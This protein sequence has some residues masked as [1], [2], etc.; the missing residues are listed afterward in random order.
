[1]EQEEVLKIKEYVEIQRKDCRKLNEWLNSVFEPNVKSIV[2]WINAFR[3]DFRDC[4][5]EMADLIL[6]LKSLN[7]FYEKIESIDSQ[8]GAQCDWSKNYLNLLH[9][10][11]TRYSFAFLA[12][13][14]CNEKSISTAMNNDGWRRDVVNIILQLRDRS[15]EINIR[16][17][18]NAFAHLENFTLFK[19]LN[20]NF[21]I[22]GA[23]GSGKSSF[24]RRTR[25]ILG[26]NVV[27]IASQKFFEFRPVNSWSIGNNCRQNLWKY[28]GQDKLYKGEH[29]DSSMGEDLTTVVSALFEEK[30][31]LATDYF[32]RKTTVRKDSTLEKVIDL[33]EKILV[34]RKL[35]VDKGNI[36]VLTSKGSK[37][38]FM[39][40]SDGEKVVFYYV[41]HILL[42]KENSYIIVDEPENHLH[43]ALI[44][45]LWD[46]LEQARPDCQ[47]IYLTHNLEF[48]ASRNNVEKIWMREFIAPDS[49]K[50]EKLPTDK[51]LPEIL[52]MELLGS[53]KPIL[54]CEGKKDSLDYKLYTRL[55]PNYTV[56]PVEG[57]LQVISYTRAFNN[58]Y[59]V[60]HNRAIG[61]IDGDFHKQEQKDAWK[62]S[63]VYSLDVQEV[64]NILCDEDVLNRAVGYFHANQ[65]A[66]EKAKEKLFVELQKYIDNQ[67]TE[68]AVQMINNRFKENMLK[69]LRDLNSLKNNV[70]ELAAEIL[71]N[72]DAFVGERKECLQ[73]IIGAKNFAEGVKRFNNKGLLTILTNDI[74][75]DYRNRVFKMLDENP[76]LLE[77]LRNRYFADVPQNL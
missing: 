5:K 21:V 69:N 77:I 48:A 25:E 76:D 41:A 7:S 58:S 31:E 67:C 35:E 53:R 10:T 16:E 59:K 20:N 47:F 27:I 70:K 15:L 26:G 63:S 56:I 2:E 65:N 17:I 11:I 37:Y 75:K 9:R 61:I 55:F 54:F 44:T 42:A 13:Y 51:D 46:K 18:D 38:P 45:K 57:H 39:S 33:W 6:R 22:I 1:M 73:R 68:C 8:M 3:P 72:V 29:H 36:H 14:F 74:E 40:L 28:Q 71:E 64:E 4:E 24:S 12:E 43:L 62:E 52:Y 50:M 32:D 23:N 60:H 34:H 30:M 66:L 49:W 19:H